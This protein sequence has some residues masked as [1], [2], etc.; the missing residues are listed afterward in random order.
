M[1]APRTLADDL[2]EKHRQDISKATGI[3]AT[4]KFVPDSVPVALIG[5][6][7]SPDARAQLG[8]RLAELARALVHGGIKGFADAPPPKPPIMRATTPKERGEKP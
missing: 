5:D 2:D 6:D 7:R 3:P 1:T 8:D 4:K